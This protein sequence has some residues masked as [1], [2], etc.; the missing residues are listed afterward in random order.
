MGGHKGAD[1][2]CLHL[3]FVE[4]GTECGSSAPGQLSLPTKIFL[5]YA[6]EL[7]GLRAEE[8]GVNRL[9]FGCRIISIACTPA[10]VRQL[11]RL[12]PDSTWVETPSTAV[13][14]TEQVVDDIRHK[15]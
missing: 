8:L 12:S 11:S 4:C 14:P 1:Q 7:S 2:A 13:R 10:C 15:L 9:I 5:V 3:V 6:R